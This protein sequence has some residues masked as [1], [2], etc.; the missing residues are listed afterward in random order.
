MLPFLVFFCTA[1][2]WPLYS[3]SFSLSL[4]FFYRSISRP[5]FLFLSSFPLPPSFS[6]PSSL[7]SSPPHPPPPPP[8]LS[9]F[10]HPPFHTPP[11]PPPPGTL[12]S[13]YILAPLRGT[14]HYR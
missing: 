12:A 14:A 11:P 8:P 3:F 9:N 13:F 5:F 10:H 6:P 1:H 7:F 2:I 4:S